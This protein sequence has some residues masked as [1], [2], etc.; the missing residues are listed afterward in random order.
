[1]K[2]S[3]SENFPM[4]LLESE[5]DKEWSFTSVVGV[6]GIEQVGDYLHTLNYSKMCI[7][8]LQ[9]SLPSTMAISS[10]VNS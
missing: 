3:R 8:Q 7:R 6:R 10:V 4:L 1:L 9:L 2:K 5:R